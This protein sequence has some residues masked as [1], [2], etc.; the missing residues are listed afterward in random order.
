VAAGQGRRHESRDPLSRAILIVACF[1]A[2]YF[3]SDLA[4][5]RGFMTFKVRAIGVNLTE[6]TVMGTTF[7][8][9]QDRSLEILHVAFY[10]PLLGH[11]TWH[12]YRDMLR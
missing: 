5:L 6:A 9:G 12:A 11:A 7:V 4:R 8:S 2:Y 3:V 10:R 1:L